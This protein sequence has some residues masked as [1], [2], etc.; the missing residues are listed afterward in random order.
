[1]DI[2]YRGTN[3]N[4][5]QIQP[6]GVTVQ[7]ELEKALF[8]ILKKETAVTGS[9]RTDTGVHAMQQ[10]AHIDIDEIDPQKLTFKLNSFLNG[11][12]SINGI[13]PVKTEA[14]A[15]FDATDRT[16]HYHLHQAKNPFKKGLSYYFNPELDIA[17]INEACEIIKGWQNFECF[18]KV[19]TEVNNFNCEIFQAKWIQDGS[20]HMFEISANRFLRGMVRAVV[21]TLIDVGLGKTSLEDFSAILES[22]DRRRAGRA[23]PAEGLFLQK[24][25]YPEDIYLD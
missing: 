14:H 20:N 16:Y 17:K 7:E 4:G 8:T 11:D 1:M 22:N 13:R 25:V 12:I 6:N 19:H 21:G 2:S 18:S 15:R 23:V 24:V 5:W 10:I 3:F 9:G